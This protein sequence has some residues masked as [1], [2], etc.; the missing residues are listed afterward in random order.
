MKAK[1]LLFTLI[2]ALGCAFIATSCSKTASK[3]EMATGVVLILNQSCY[4]LKLNDSTSVYFSDY[5]E[6]NGLQG[7]TFEPDSLELSVSYGTG[8]FVDNKGTI[9]TNAHVV[10]GMSTKDS[11][12]LASD[13]ISIIQDSLEAIYN[14][15]D[16]E[17]QEIETAMD[18]PDLDQEDQATLRDYLLALR[19]QQD[20]YIAA[21]QYLDNIDHSK[22]SVEYYNEVS[23]A[24]N[25]SKVEDEEDFIKC[26]ILTVNKDVDLALIRLED[27]STPAGRYVF[28]V[29]ESE[30]E[31][32]A[33]NQVLSMLGYNYGIE[34][35]LTNEGIKLQ[36]NNGTISQQTHDEIMYSIPALP[37]SSGSPVVN[38]DGELCA[39]NYAGLS[40]TQSFNYG[41]RTQHLRNLIA[42]IN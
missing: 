36:I 2:I 5:D 28:D 25:N 27:Q 30:P 8:F 16:E 37:G 42:S 14:Q 33:D 12:I 31:Y 10:S 15:C 20:D 24:Y 7:L 1:T 4:E 21:Y 11:T 38:Q 17:I 22:A 40:E 18:N 3:E 26:E 32:L 41:I 23:I 6:E 35:A 13:L 34:L 39:I 9:A 29:P 19:E